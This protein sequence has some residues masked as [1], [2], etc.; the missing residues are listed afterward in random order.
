MIVKPGIQK[1]R[2]KDIDENKNTCIRNYCDEIWWVKF[3][4]PNDEVRQLANTFNVMLSRLQD[5][6]Q[7]VK[8][9]LEM[10]RNFVADGSHELR[11]PLTTL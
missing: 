7:K 6:F 11:T 1:G 4:G 5:A 9:A 10:H 3:Q 2:K 8:Y